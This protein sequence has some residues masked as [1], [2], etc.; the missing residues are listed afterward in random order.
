M[1]DE[2]DLTTA[3]GGTTEPISLRCSQQNLMVLCSGA[4]TLWKSL[5]NVRSCHGSL[6]AS[7]FV[8]FVVD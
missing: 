2:P 7:H 1:C 5:W 6:L 3:F 4:T 8:G